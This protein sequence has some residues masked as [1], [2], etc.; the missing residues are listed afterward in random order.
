MDDQTTTNL[1]ILPA[2]VLAAVLFLN[3]SSSFCVSLNVFTTLRLCLT[4]QILQHCSTQKDALD[5]DCEA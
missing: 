2:N 5:A 1:K 3:S 4:T